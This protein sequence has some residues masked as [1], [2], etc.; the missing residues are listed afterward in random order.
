MLEGNGHAD[1]GQL[2][3]GGEHAGQVGGPARSGDD[4]AQAA[5]RGA[6]AVGD[7]VLG[8]AVGGDDA[9]LAGDVELGQ[10]GD[11]GFH[12]RPVRV[13][14][15]D[16]ADEWGVSSGRELDVEVGGHSVS[17]REVDEAGAAW[18]LDRA[19][20]WVSRWLKSP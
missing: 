15:H 7:H 6:P 20:W 8:H 12:G 2:G 10:G 16:D 19:R 1:N 5:L 14:S 3:E 17:F 11:C 4:D 13:R 18:P 9:D